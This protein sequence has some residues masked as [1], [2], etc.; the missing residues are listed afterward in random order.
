[1]RLAVAND[2]QVAEEMIGQS[3]CSSSEVRD[4]P[5]LLEDPRFG[6]ATNLLISAWGRRPS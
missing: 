6:V 3:F 2:S 5:D 1:L 4:A